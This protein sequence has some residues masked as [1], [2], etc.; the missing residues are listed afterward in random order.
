MTYIAASDAK[1]D[2]IAFVRKSWPLDNNIS[3]RPKL[4]NALNSVLRKLQPKNDTRV[5]FSDRRVASI[6]NGEP[7]AKLKSWEVA[8]LHHLLDEA[9]YEHQELT[10]KIEVLEKQL[11][12]LGAHLAS[13]KMA[14]DRN[15]Q[16]RAGAKAD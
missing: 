11:N 7:T 2:I 1:P 16:T 5:F 15:G 3:V 14:A 9:T 12:D 6:L 10:A 13:L 8:A 4:R